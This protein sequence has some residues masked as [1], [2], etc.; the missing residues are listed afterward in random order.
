MVGREGLPKRQR[1]I[2]VRD[3]RVL[4]RVGGEGINVGTSGSLAAPCLRSESRWPER[5]LE[6]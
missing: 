3:I 1:H 2:G 5:D 4:G 6:G